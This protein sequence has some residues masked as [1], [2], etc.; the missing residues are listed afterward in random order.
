[1]VRF[2][3]PSGRGI[4]RRDGVLYL[5]HLNHENWYDKHILQ[6]GAGEAEQRA[7]FIRHIRRRQCDTFLDIGA[8]IGTYAACVALQASCGTIIA[9]EPDERSYERLRAHLLINDLT[10]KVQTRMVAVSNHNGTV[11]FI[12]APIHIAGMSKIC[13]GGSDG[14]SVS[15]VRLD[16]ELPLNGHRIALKIDI[17]GHELSALDGMKSL[18]HSNECF[19]QVECWKPNAARFIA[20]MQAEGYRY[21]HRISEDHYFDKVG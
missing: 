4:V 10:E 7:F 21:L 3:W 2:L 13:E 9:F 1:M 15:A 16:D 18:L 8:H 5:L 20:A 12:R 17:E 19:L 14:F 6:W 11:P